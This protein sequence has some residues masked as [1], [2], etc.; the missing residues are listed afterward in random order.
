M[1]REIEIAN[2]SAK[3]I[4]F[5]SHNRL[6]TVLFINSKGDQEARGVSRTLQ[7]I[8][9]EGCTLKCPYAVLEVLVN[10]AGLKG[11]PGAMIST[12][13]NGKQRAT[14]KDLVDSWR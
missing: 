13:A 8:C 10:Y 4:K 12:T 2:L 7:C 6:V 5:D 11:P 9:K 14:K 1:M 3:D